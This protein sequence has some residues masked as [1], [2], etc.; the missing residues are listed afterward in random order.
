MNA[1]T[2]NALTMNALTMNGAPAPTPASDEARKQ[3]VSYKLTGPQLMSAASSA[4]M[5][6]L[7]SSDPTGAAGSPTRGQLAV[8]LLKYIYSCA[9]PA[10]VST[11][12][13]GVVGQPGGS[14]TLQGQLGL[15]S[16]WATGPCDDQCRELVSACV[17]ARVNAFGEPVEISMRAPSYGLSASA[18]EQAS[19][20]DYEGAFFGNLFGRGDGSDF[21]GSWDAYACHPD[22][23]TDNGELIAVTHRACARP[24]GYCPITIVGPCSASCSGAEGAYTSCAKP[25]G[26]SSYRPV[27]V[28]LKPVDPVCG[29]AVCEAGEAATCPVDC[30]AALVM[31]I[32][33]PGFS[34]R[35]VASV[36][37]PIHRSSSIIAVGIVEAPPGV[38]SA[39]Q[40]G[41]GVTLP[42][43]SLRDMFVVR[44]EADPSTSGEPIRVVWSVREPIP[45]GSGPAGAF[46]MDPKDIAADPDGDVAVT[47]TGFAALYDKDTG[48]RVWRTQDP[49]AIAYDTVWINPVGDVV[50]SGLKPAHS[51]TRVTTRYTVVAGYAFAS[52]T[53]EGSSI[54][55][56]ARAIRKLDE[57][58][59]EYFESKAAGQKIRL[60]RL[61]SDGAQL[62]SVDVALPGIQQPIPRNLG[63]DDATGTVVIAGYDAADGDAPKTPFIA[64]VS[65][66]GAVT[67]LNIFRS[68]LDRALLI[69]RLSLYDGR[70]YAAGKFSGPTDFH[71]S[72]GGPAITPAFDVGDDTFVARY[73]FLTGRAEWARTDGGN[74][75]DLL[76]AF[77]IDGTGKLWTFGEFTG[78]ARVDWKEVSGSND[79]GSDIFLERSYP[80]HNLALHKTAEQSSTYS[81]QGITGTADKAVDGITDGVY[82]EG[83]VAA[84]N[85]ELGA[86]WQVDLGAIRWIDHVIIYR[87][88]DGAG[89]DFSGFT[90]QASGTGN[91]EADFVPKYQYAL[92]PNPPTGKVLRI[93][94]LG[95]IRYVRIREEQNKSLG[96]AEVQIWGH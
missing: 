32:K 2:M 7:S 95:N 58:H 37:Q 40:V 63:V 53:S 67:W 48:Q 13:T 27:A 39:I 24:G 74:G 11:T 61:S 54:A 51:A 1:L 28:Y 12:L 84:T 87:R 52:F 75:S 65:P 16:S 23:A 26:V 76:D 66:A 72:L 42:Q 9:M 41:P 64:Q 21:T 82:A 59:Y 57:V 25:D 36:V 69:E 70:I 81:C 71:G 86:S 17:L 5:S 20:N 22:T 79:G 6:A 38:P 31:P 14:V 77:S 49:Q 29:N 83:S 10:D 91:A 62:S 80:G 35:I 8:Q 43:A 94:G 19:F 93:D 88:T 33:S 96:L 60:R 92:D 78:A 56:R 47:G 55:S 18:A 45:V 15:A 50:A 30:G 90:L 89:A 34:A 3:L 73:D 4:V 44:Y 85:A 68:Q 46:N